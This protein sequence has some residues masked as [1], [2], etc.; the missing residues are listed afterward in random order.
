MSGHAFLVLGPL[1][2]L[3]GAGT[4]LTITRRKPRLLL[5]LLL[6]RANSV[7]PAAQLLHHLWDGRPP[8]SAVANL[9][10]YVTELRRVLATPAVPG[11]ERLQTRPG[12]YLLRVDDG[13]SDV[14]RFAALAV[15]GADELAAGSPAAAMEHLSAALALWRGPV[16]SGLDVP[17]LLRPDVEELE[18]KRLRA[19]EHRAQAWLDLGCPTVAAAELRALTGQ[20]P[21]RERPWEL[22]MLALH[23]G[24]RTDEALAAYRRARAVLAGELGIEPGPGLRRMQQAILTGDPAVDAPP[25]PGRVAAVRPR[26]LPPDVVTVVGRAPLLETLDA[27]VRPDGPR[28]AA[29]VLAGPAGV[30][31]TTLAVQWAHRAAPHFPDGQLYADLHGYS[32]SPAVPAM[33]VLTGF[34][35]ALGVRP[36][37]VPTEQ[38][39]AAALYRS[40]L[41]DRRVLVVLD[42]VSS[43]EQARPLLPGSAG[44]AALITSRDRL[45]GLTATLDARVLPLPELSAD[46]SVALLAAV[47]GAD[48]VEAEA[49]AARQLAQLCAGLPLALRI[50]AANLLRWPGQ[51]LAG[52]LAEL[53]GGDLLTKLEVP[54]DE[55][56]GLRRT[57]DFSYDAV[58][59]AAAQFFCL[60]GCVPGEEI[61][62]AGAAALAGADVFHT[63][64]LLREL[65]ASHL[66]QP[67]GAD[68]F[69]MHDLVR[70]YAAGRAAD[71]AE[72]TRDEALGRLFEYYL[73]IADR[74]AKALYPDFRRLPDERPAETAEKPF[75]P[76]EARQWLLTEHPNLLAAI[77]WAAEHGPAAV[78]W[79]L[80]DVLRGFFHSHRLD[81]EWEA[82]ATAGL[83]AARRAEDRHAAGA[84]R[85]SLGALAWSRGSYQQALTELGAARE[86]YLAAGALD[87]ADSVLQAFGVVYLDLGQLEDAIEHF[88]AALGAAEERGTEAQV[89]NSL[90]NLGATLLDHGRLA[91]GIRSNERALEICRTVGSPHAAAIAQCNLGYGY[92]ATGQLRRA[93]AVLTE[94]LAVLRELGSREDEADALARL[95]AVHRIAGDAAA[96]ACAAQAL[97]IAREAGNRRFETDAL[98]ELGHIHRLARET[99][100]A[101]ACY[102]EMLQQAKET[103]YRRGE[104]IATIGLSAVDPATASAHATEALRLAERGGFRPLAELARL[105]LAEATLEAGDTAA[106]GEHARTAAGE[107]GRAG[108]RIGEADAW[109]VQG[110]VRLAS[111]D[112]EAARDCAQEAEAALRDSGAEAVMVR[113][114]ALLAEVS[115]ARPSG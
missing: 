75:A 42:N 10:S 115:A 51:P 107:L 34:L 113:V 62:L 21:L 17:E 38:A 110:R 48:R 76:A 95:A 101:R 78:A 86:C 71:L 63:A 81:A 56:L 54:G 72:R 32:P 99:D 85:H 114:R 90:I 8:A 13:E 20:H 1:E 108:H 77:R 49:D 104:I 18:E 98:G 88:T 92:R 74:A 112:P 89:A 23:R 40:L 83:A 64:H 25:E 22:F 55:R 65:V 31:K 15:R 80:A 37:Q 7:V 30:G 67:R 33:Q 47:L 28:P 16:L 102:L 9:Q 105:R 87:G 100:A 53:T 61:S 24:G 66:V 84:M 109:V 91:E 96:R 73:R 29:V 43:A 97:V 11:T 4:A 60:L 39:D 70:A 57:L 26:Q 58:S 6:F 27:L 79:R 2:V 68:R 45:A 111:G 94:A 5:A 41:A 52:Y 59:D 3:D 46:D 35:H 106:A 44:S 50:V 12:G 19:A 103:G 93:H 36:G 69:G 14:G 82:A